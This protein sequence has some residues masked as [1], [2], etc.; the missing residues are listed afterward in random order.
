MFGADVH[1]L[2]LLANK[3]DE[4]AGRLSTIESRVDNRVASMSWTGPDATRFR[5][6][7][8][9]SSAPAISDAASNLEQAAV[10]IRGDAQRQEQASAGG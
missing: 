5:E 9:G 10:A 4:I 1:A 7:W 2:R 3:L 6:T 8:H